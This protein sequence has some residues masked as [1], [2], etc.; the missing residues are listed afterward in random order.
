MRAVEGNENA[1]ERWSFG[2][3]IVCDAK[4]R[5]IPDNCRRCFPGTFSF[6]ETEG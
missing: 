6:P 5:R 2:Q 1:D 3:F 4:Y